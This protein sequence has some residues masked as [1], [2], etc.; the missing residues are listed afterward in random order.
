MA[1]PLPGSMRISIC[2]RPPHSPF[3]RRLPHLVQESVGEWACKPN[4]VEG[5]HLSGT[6]VAP[7]LKRPTRGRGGPPLTGPKARAPSYSGLLRAGFARP[8]C[9]QPAGALL[10]HHF[11]L[12]GHSRRCVSVALSEGHPS[13][14]LA[15][16]LPCGVRTFLRPADADP[17]PPGPL[18]NVKYTRPSHAS[19]FCSGGSTGC[20]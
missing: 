12:T 3:P 16:A 13:W 18:S 2:T 20:G 15:S 5:G 1:R 10:P 14:L 7:R 11:T 4:S 19:Q 8:G 9:H 17:R 6:R